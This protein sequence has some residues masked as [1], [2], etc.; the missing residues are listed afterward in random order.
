MI[1]LYYDDVFL[2]FY[3]YYYNHFIFI[4]FYYWWWIYSR[5]LHAST[6]IFFVSCGPAMFV[7]TGA[8][9]RGSFAAEELLQT[10]QLDDWRGYARHIHRFLVYWRNRTDYWRLGPPWCNYW[11]EQKSLQGP[12]QASLVG[13]EGCHRRV[14]GTRGRCNWRT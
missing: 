7:L 8:F 10:I 1:L 3:Y 4:Y 9:I 6:P 12:L 13:L 5:L 14:S 2:F 11:E